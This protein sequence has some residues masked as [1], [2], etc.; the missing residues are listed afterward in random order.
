MFAEQAI[1]PQGA[2]AA[3]QQFVVLQPEVHLVGFGADDLGGDVLIILRQVAHP[4]LLKV[5]DSPVEVDFSRQ[6]AQQ[7]FVQDVAEGCHGRKFVS[8]MDLRRVRLQQRQL[9]LPDALPAK[10]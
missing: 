5:V 8:N 3:G 6:V 9:S 1:H 4:P 2:T 7:V 10:A